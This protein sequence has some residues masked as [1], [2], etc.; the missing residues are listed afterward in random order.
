MTDPILQLLIDLGKL[1]GDINAQ[2]LRLPAPDPLK[3]VLQQADSALSKTESR[4]QSQIQ[5]AAPTSL[6]RKTF[7]PGIG[8]IQEVSTRLGTGSIT[9][10]FGPRRR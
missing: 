10:I 5:S 8:E 6:T 9:A 2:L 4:I 7:L 1:R 3:Q